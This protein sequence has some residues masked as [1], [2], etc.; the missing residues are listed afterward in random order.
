MHPTIRTPL[1]GTYL[2]YVCFRREDCAP[3]LDC[4][5]GPC[6][7]VLI[8]CSPTRRLKGRLHD[9]RLNGQLRTP[10]LGQHI[11][12]ASQVLS[13]RSSNGSSRVSYSKNYFII[14]RGCATVYSACEQVRHMVSPSPTP[15]APECLDGI[16]KNVE[17]ACTHDM[18][19]YESR[20]ASCAQHLA[21]GHWGRHI[22]L[23]AT[24]SSGIDSPT[25]A[26]CARSTCSCAPPVFDSCA[27]RSHFSS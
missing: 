3:A 14:L 6:K 12:H 27:P 16:P 21:S 13:T 15:P 11:A 24:S 2:S 1:F 22:S 25:K 17:A 7:G 20:R 18:Y 8:D 26:T 9:N 4:T 19:R 10:P 5:K 23:S